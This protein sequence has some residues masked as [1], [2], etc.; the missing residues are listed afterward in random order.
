[1]FRAD[2]FKATRGSNMTLGHRERSMKNTALLGLLIFSS[3]ISA[4]VGWKD[5]VGSPVPESDSQKSVNGFGGLLVVTP[6]KDWE[7]KWSTP[8]ETAPEF[9]HTSAVERGGELFILTMFTNPQPDDSGVADVM[10]DIDVRRPDGSASTHAEGATC[11]KSVLGG[12]PQNIRLCGPVV[13]FV[14]EPSD[15][16]GTW[17]VQIT[18]RDNVRKVAIPLSTTFE[19]I[20]DDAAI[21]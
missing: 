1:M 15:P 10:M 8:P 4:E 11:F 9:S 21:K 7:E 6:D 3:A 18:L 2:A 5:E 16:T 13:G 12:S 17:S 14:G 19:L 20:D